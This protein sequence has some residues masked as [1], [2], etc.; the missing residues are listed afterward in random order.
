MNTADGRFTIYT[1]LTLLCSL[2]SFLVGPVAAL[3]TFVQIAAVIEILHW[4]GVPV[5]AQTD[6]F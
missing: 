5:A 1:A 2:A 4:L 6:Q 3:W